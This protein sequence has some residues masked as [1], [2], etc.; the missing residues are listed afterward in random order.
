M[1]STSSVLS[2]TIAILL[3]TELQAAN[4]P[5][6]GASAT[7]DQG[8]G[9]TIGSTLDTSIV[10]S[11]SG[12]GVYSAVPPGGLF[13]DQSAFWTAASPVTSA[14]GLIFT[15]P[16]FYVDGEHHIQKFRLSLTTDAI[17]SAAGNW[18][19]VSPDFAWST[20][21]V[22]IANAGSNTFLA[23]GVGKTTYRLGIASPVTAATGFRLEVFTH[24]YNEL[25]GL[26]ATLGRAGN[27][28]F[29]LSQFLVDTPAGYNWALGG[30]PTS[31]GATYPGQPADFL[32][33]G[34]LNNQ[35]HPADPPT[36]NGFFF[37]VDLG[38][39]V[40]LSSI[41]LFNRT[42]GCCPDRL[43]NFRVDV[44]DAV[45]TSV[46]NVNLHTDGSSSGASG[47]DTITEGMGVGTF[48]G[49]YIRVTNLSG[50]AYNPQ[51]AEIKAFGTAIPE[52]GSALLAAMGGAFFVFRRRRAAE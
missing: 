15:M 3:A 39:N 27:G 22:T 49:R 46:W 7:F 52:P 33:D 10:D 36:Q 50:S 26:P 32:V 25:D 37:T 18:A 51:I 17:P 16:Q 44:L 24:D 41:D 19:P 35:A 28:N 34:F 5:L 14:N 21:G 45:G 30:S 13:S 1:N 23:T 38:G 12:W 6:S 40:D 4:I 8:G 2:A 47:V 31:S 43:S 9:F 48:E 11:G 20:G 42:D 29:V